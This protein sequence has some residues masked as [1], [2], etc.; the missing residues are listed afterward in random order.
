MPLSCLTMGNLLHALNALCKTTL[1]C[2]LIVPLVLCR[3]WPSLRNLQPY[4]LHP[5]V[6]AT[7]SSIVGQNSKVL[8]V[9]KADCQNKASGQWVSAEQACFISGN[10]QPTVANVARRAGMLLV[11]APVVIYQVHI[12]HPHTA[13]LFML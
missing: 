4:E 9:P 12:P 7:S 3:L 10:V 5:L 8:W 2:T 11:D 13:I 6:D 1:T